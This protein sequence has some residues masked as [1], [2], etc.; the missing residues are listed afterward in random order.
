GDCFLKVRIRYIP[1]KTVLEEF[2]IN[3]QW[4]WMANFPDNFRRGLLDHEKG[5]AAIIEKYF[6]YLINKLNSYNSIYCGS[7]GYVSEIKTFYCGEAIKEYSN[8]YHTLA[9]AE[10]NEYDAASYNIAWFGCYHTGERRARFS[11][12]KR[13]FRSN[14]K[15]LRNVAR[16]YIANANKYWKLCMGELVTY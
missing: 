2:P 16:F 5:H 8:Y 11:A 1:E 13:E 14:A 3:S 10:S 7:Y 15:S 6:G 12:K 4:W 9:E